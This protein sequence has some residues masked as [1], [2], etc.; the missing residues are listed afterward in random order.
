MLVVHTRFGDIEI[1]PET[2]LTFPKGLLGFESL[3]RYKLLHE[4]KPDPTVFWLQSLDDADVSFN[5]VQA[6]SLGIEYQIELSDEETALIDLESPD[7]AVLLLTLARQDDSQKPLA[8]NTFAPLVL[9]T[10]SRKGLQKAGL[11][12]DIVFRN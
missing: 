5:V 11:R 7:D 10:K 9:S 6:N 3:T 4:D 8:A 2:I 1:D 12:A